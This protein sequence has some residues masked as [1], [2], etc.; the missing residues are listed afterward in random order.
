[1]ERV[2]L[3]FEGMEPFV[4]FLESFLVEAGTGLAYVDEMSALLV[5]TEHQRSEMLTATFRI[6][7]AANHAFLALRDLNLQPFPRALFLINAVAFLGE[8]AFESTLAC[9]V[10]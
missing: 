10:E 5:E 3:G 1:M 2:G 7:V 4:Y 6:G 8:D 9:H